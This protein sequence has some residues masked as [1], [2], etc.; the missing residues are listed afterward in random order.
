MSV[1]QAENSLAPAKS[2]TGGR[3]RAQSPFGPEPGGL[4]PPPPPPPPPK[5]RPGSPERNPIKFELPEIFGYSFTKGDLKDRWN[6]KEENLSDYFNYGM[7]EDI[8]RLYRKKMRDMNQIMRKLGAEQEGREETLQTES[9][10]T[11]KVIHKGEGEEKVEVNLPLKSKGLDTG[12]GVEFGGL[13]P[14]V[15][16]GVIKDELVLQLNLNPEK[17]WLKHIDM[18]P[19][20]LFKSVIIQAHMDANSHGFGNYLENSTTNQL[21]QQEEK[22]LSYFKKNYKGSQ[23][24]LEKL[25]EI[26]KIRRD[27]LKLYKGK[28]FM[29]VDSHFMNRGREYEKVKFGE[30]RR[31]RNEDLW[32][33]DSR[34]E[35][36]RNVN[37]YKNYGEPRKRMSR[38]ASQCDG[39]APD[40][41]KSRNGRRKERRKKK[42]KGKKDR[43]SGAK[44]NDT[45]HERSL[46]ARSENGSKKGGTV[47]KRE[48]NEKRKKKQIDN[49][50]KE[51]TREF[52]QNR[53]NP[54]VIPRKIEY[55]P[56]DYPRD[57]ERKPREKEEIF[58]SGRTVTMKRNYRD[59]KGPS[60]E[61]YS[62]EP[63]WERSR[64]REFRPHWRRDRRPAPRPWGRSR[65][66]R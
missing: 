52:E 51:T 39:E 8:F 58:L 37:I 45:T 6:D 62:R 25:W 48:E 59:F 56:R 57:R 17:F 32:G 2:G 44:R 14:V 35:R 40:G 55:K 22:L 9:D 15:L 33:Q 65:Y 19:A 1:S 11:R 18:D 50:L 60:R 54:S 36:Q 29:G 16:P 20:N 41:R 61:R 24:N 23:G 12:L 64:E 26:G 3:S 7:N 10:K 13:G 42:K 27:D 30:D 47:R 46:S 53:Q 34:R 21:V 31:K 43:K 5:S 4:S 63:S 28:H 49:L 38:S 66:R